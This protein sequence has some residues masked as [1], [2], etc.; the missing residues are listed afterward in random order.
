MP[1]FFTSRHTPKISVWFILSTYTFH[2]A[3]I[4]LFISQLKVNPLLQ[5]IISREKIS[6]FFIFQQLPERWVQLFL[7]KPHIGASNN[8]SILSKQTHY[9]NCSHCTNG[10]PQYA[11][12]H[13]QKSE[14]LPKDIFHIF[15]V[16]K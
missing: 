5:L 13:S 12:L 7:H 2:Q 15:Q 8:N 16:F 14:L 10:G 4:H 1:A 3:I 6:H 11:E 9:P